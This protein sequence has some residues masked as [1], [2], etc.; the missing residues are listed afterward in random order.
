M[1]NTILCIL[2]FIAFVYILANQKI[3]NSLL[4]LLL[5]PLLILT[6]LMDAATV[7]GF[8]SNSSLHLVMIISVYACLMAVSGFDELIGEAFQHMTRNINGKNRER[9]LFGLI[10]VLAAACSTIMANSS[11]TMAMVPAL[12]GISRKMKIS[13]SKLVLFV[14]YASTLGGACT[15]IGTETNIFANAALEEAGITPFAMFDFAWVGIPIA[16][17]G[18]LYMVMFHHLDKSYDD[19]DDDDDSMPTPKEKTGDMVLIMK[20]QRL[21]ICLGFFSFIAVL[22]LNSFDFFKALD[23][24]AYAYGYL[25]IGLLY[26]AKCFTW[27]E[28]IHGFNFDRMFMIVGLL[29][30]IKMITTSSLGDWI[31]ALLERSIGAS[32]SMY[33]IFTV[34]FVVTVVI[35]QFMNN[36]AACGV[37]SPIAIT[38]ATTLG[39]DPRAF[40]MAIAI[41]AGCGY[42]TPFASGTNQRMSVF[43]KSTILDYMRYGWP[44]IIITYLCALLILPHVFPFF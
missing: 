21:G 23:I 24:N 19:L 38:L 35:T 10:F 43:A 27:K 18:G 44:L 36:L 41:A 16:I 17:L 3:P 11:V 4:F 9:G 33:F 15:L 14:I 25:T 8:F 6:H 7:W 42:L 31:A 37:I 40:I 26:T 12:Y 29:S 28:V 13:R 1:T 22:L 30:V 32:T 20:R 2:I 5:S 39:A 34:L